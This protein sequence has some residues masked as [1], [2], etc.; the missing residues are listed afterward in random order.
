MREFLCL[1]DAAIYHITTLENYELIIDR[2]LESDTLGR[3]FVCRSGDLG[4]LYSIAISQVLTKKNYSGFAILKIP[5][6]LNTFDAR[7]FSPDFQANEI[8]MP[9]QSILHQC[10]IEAKCIKL[11][12]VVDDPIDQ[13]GNI[14]NAKE[15][16]L[17]NS[18]ALNEALEI[19]YETDKGLQY[20][21]KAKRENGIWSFERTYT[22]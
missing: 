8:T 6:A 15:A 14:A 20:W 7:A 22:K 11:L 1:P 10:H 9:F 21:V 17:A 5:L 2:G 13:V 4:I 12:S 19:T 18:I 3:I 16:S